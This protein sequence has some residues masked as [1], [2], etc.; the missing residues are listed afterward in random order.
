MLNP[1]L[2]AIGI[3]FSGITVGFI[4]Q[5]V[6]ITF[7]IVLVFIIM[8]YFLYVIPMKFRAACLA[9]KPLN[10]KKKKHSDERKHEQEIHGIDIV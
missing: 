8:A 2:P 5:T 10:F 6:W 3:M 7:F 1:L 4:D 9:K